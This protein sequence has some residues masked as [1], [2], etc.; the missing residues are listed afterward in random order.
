[1]RRRQSSASTPTGSRLLA[2]L[3]VKESAIIQAAMRFV[4]ISRDVVV[5]FILARS[6][7]LV[8]A[9]HLA[10]WLSLSSLPGLHTTF[11]RAKR[12]PCYLVGFF[13][14][15]SASDMVSGRTSRQEW[16][17]ILCRLIAVYTQFSS[18]LMAI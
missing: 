6:R 15:A 7:R 5:K 4:R 2:E 14:C 1:M 8:R 13:S 3:M 9:V 10:H 12:A 11:H 18:H 16:L 17:R